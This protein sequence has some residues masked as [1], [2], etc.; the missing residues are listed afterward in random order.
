MHTLIHRTAV[1]LIAL[2]FAVSAVWVPQPAHAGGGGP[3][4]GATEATQILNLGE[5]GTIAGLSEFI[6]A[7]VDLAADFLGSLFEKEYILDA[8]AWEVAKAL[9]SELTS[10]IVDWV[11]SGFEGSPTFVQDL[12]D[13]IIDAA[14]TA[15][16]QTLT[17]I[18]GPASFICDPFQLDVQVALAAEYSRTD[19]R[20]SPPACTASEALDNL[21]DFFA[22]EDFTESRGWAQW[23][24]VSSRPQQYTTYGSY[25]AA[26]GRFEAV[27]RNEAGK[28]ITLLDFGDGF[29][30]TEI[31]EVVEGEGVPVE[32]CFISTPGKIIEEQL[33][34]NLDSGR[35][36]LVAAD[37][38]NEIIGAVI[39][40]LAE[41]ALTGVGGLLG[42]SEG[43]AVG[44]GGGDA[45]APTALDELA[46]EIAEA[47]GFETVADLEEQVAFEEEYIA[48][49]EL[50][51][52]RI[53]AFV[54]SGLAD[55]GEES[56]AAVLTAQFE[57]E[58]E[59][60][61][62]NIAAI[63]ELI[64]E[65]AATDPDDLVTIAEIGSEFR[66]LP[67][68]DAGDVAETNR[69][70]DA[71]LDAAD[72]EGEFVPPGD[73]GPLPGG[74]GPGGGGIP[75]LPGGGGGPPA[76][77]GGGAPPAPGG[78]GTP[79]APGGGLGATP[80]PPTGG[81]P[82]LPGG[83]GP[84]APDGGGGLPTPGGGGTPTAPGGGGAPPA[85]GGGGTPTAPG[86]GGLPTPGGGTP[87]APDGGGAPD[88]APDGGGGGLTLPPAPGGL[89]GGP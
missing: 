7:G 45:D 3:G 41:E 44:I 31:C 10:S 55:D 21:E 22:N 75:G 65:L 66:S 52:A 81:L 16:G 24:D 11:N 80:P 78:G 59:Q 54:E 86:D 28:E 40:F 69:L 39:G 62:A 72:D 60:A 1:G 87:T 42:L 32:D 5:L 4:G 36:T 70:T 77:G 23:F 63:E 50:N 88:P 89:P 27:F 33:T 2:V 84:P 37:E 83:G 19:G 14:D 26:E 85:P 20:Q 43:Y 53:A 8:I 35:Q 25:L 9:M 15:V 17:E 38:I 79:T 58:I 76:P 46:D 74:G 48:T 64:G 13:V 51:I 71:F 18:G 67:L 49:L 34:F 61:E 12:Q 68:N 73:L 56:R 6:S 29:F 57:A 82:G 47:E 30:S